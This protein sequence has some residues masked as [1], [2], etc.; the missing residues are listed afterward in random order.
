[1]T[2]L[3][4]INEYISTNTLII[5]LIIL[6]TIIIFAIGMYYLP[7]SLPVK[8]VAKIAYN[9]NSLQKGENKKDI[10]IVIFADFLCSHCKESDTE[11]NKIYEKYSKDILIVYRYYPL[12][13]NGKSETAMLAVESIRQLDTTKDKTLAT[14]LYDLLF[15]KRNDWKDLSDKQFLD[16]LVKYAKT[17]KLTDTKKFRENIEKKTYMDVIKK[18]QKDAKK[19]NINSTP[20]IFINGK[21]VS[22]YDYNTIEKEIKS[23]M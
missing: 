4:R 14:Q 2:I 21:K 20:S 15:E 10:K 6:G 12:E 17:L 11:V 7:A 23:Q 8:E 22:N 1:M 18:D 3:E 5:S 16:K 9:S 19:I 13:E